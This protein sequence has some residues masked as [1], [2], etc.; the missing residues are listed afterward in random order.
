LTKFA[1]CFVSEKRIEIRQE[2]VSSINVGIGAVIGGGGGGGTNSTIEGIGAN[3][4]FDELNV[5]DPRVTRLFYLQLY[6]SVLKVTSIF[7]D[8]HNMDIEFVPGIIL[9]RRMTY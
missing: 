8:A 6:S 9:R 3:G 4:G 7:C 1:S 2:D 5:K